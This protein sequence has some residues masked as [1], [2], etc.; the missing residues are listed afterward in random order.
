ME[1]K[2]GTKLGCFPSQTRLTTLNEYKPSKKKKK[3]A[4][5]AFFLL[6]ANY[7]QIL[8][9]VVGKQRYN[10][11]DLQIPQLVQHDELSLQPLEFC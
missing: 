6:I 5:C 7:L 11:V 2:Q 3:Q 9:E 10:S 8:V 4:V 1:G